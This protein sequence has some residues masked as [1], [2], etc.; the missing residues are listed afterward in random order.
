[1]ERGSCVHSWSKD[2]LP[3]HGRKTG[4]CHRVA[5]SYRRCAYDSSELFLRSGNVLHPIREA[6]GEREGFYCN[7]SLVQ[8]IAYSS[9]PRERFLKFQG[10]PHQTKKQSHKCS[11][12]CL[13]RETGL[14]PVRWKHTPLKRARLPIPPLPRT[15]I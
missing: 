7:I 5:L 2:H 6:D 10:L 12:F 11:A 9:Y 15:M 8:R 14:E 1:M 4:F 13:V 3:P